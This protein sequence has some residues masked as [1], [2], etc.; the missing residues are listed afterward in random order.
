VRGALATLARNKWITVDQ[1]VGELR[2]RL[3]AS[4]EAE[5]ADRELAPETATAAV[6][7]ASYGLFSSSTE[8]VAL[9]S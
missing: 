2:I 7:R 9:I 3:G 1:T 5:R 8:I 4:T 6:T